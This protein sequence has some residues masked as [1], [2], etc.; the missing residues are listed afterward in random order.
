MGEILDDQLGKTLKGSEQSQH[1]SRVVALPGSIVRSKGPEGVPSTLHRQIGPAFLAIDPPG[2][3]VEQPGSTIGWSGDV[4]E[5]RG[6]RAFPL[7][8]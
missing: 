2:V 4:L 8:R 5:P 6:M 1:E 3:T 7:L